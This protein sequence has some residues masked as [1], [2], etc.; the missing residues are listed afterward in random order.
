VLGYYGLIQP[1]II[2]DEETNNKVCRNGYSVF[3]KKISE[4]EYLFVS[5]S[6]NCT[7]NQ[8]YFKNQLINKINISKV[9]FSWNINYTF[10]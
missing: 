9:L 7:I 1:F 4:N 2:I 6:I 5:F 10:V 3:L 8:S